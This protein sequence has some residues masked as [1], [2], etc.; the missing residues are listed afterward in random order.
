MDFIQKLHQGELQ[1]VDN[2][3]VDGKNR[4]PA[5]PHTTHADQWVEQYQN[6]V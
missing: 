4:D 6:Y 2:T 3:L 5:S 1:F